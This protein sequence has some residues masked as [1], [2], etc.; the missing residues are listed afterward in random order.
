MARYVVT[1]DIVSLPASGVTAGSYTN[2]DI[3]V[4]SQGIVTAASNG[5]SPAIVLDDLTDVSVGGAIVNQILQFDGA[6]WV[7]GD[8]S[9]ANLSD[10]SIPS[11]SVDEILQYDGADWVS[12]T[13]A[14]TGALT[15]SD[16]GVTV[17]GWDA[18][19]DAL[20]ALATDGYIV[21]TGAGTY[22]TRSIT[23]GT[24]SGLVITHEDGISGDTTIVVDFT[25]FA[26]VT[27]IEEDVDLIAFYND[28]VGEMEVD[29]IQNIVLSAT[30]VIGGDN[31]GSG[32]DVFKQLNTSTKLMEFRELISGNSGIVITEDTNNIEIAVSTTLNQIS[33][34]TPSLNYFIVGDGSQWTAE[35]PSAARSSLGLGTSA[36]NDDTD[37]IRVDGANA[38]AADLDMGSSV[39][40]KIINLDDPVSPQDAA[41]K[42]YVDGQIA[43]A[44]DPG[45]GLTKSVY[46]LNVG[47]GTGIL[48]NPDDVELD[49]SYTDSLYYRKTELNETTPSAPGAA[50]VGTETK[51]NLGSADTVEE[52]LNYIDVELPHALTRLR[53]ELTGT[54]QLDVG[55]P[56]VIVNTKNDVEIAQFLDGHNVAIYRDMML[57]PDFDNTR[58]L[59]FYAAFAKD[60]TL[61]GTALM[62]LSYQ[63][64]RPAGINWSTDDTLTF[65]YSDTEVY[66]LHWTIDASSLL[67]LDTFSLR[68]S[69][70]GGD[71][72]D[73]YLNYINFLTAYLIQE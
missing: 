43:I 19:L 15:A 27:S 17:Q 3:T 70:L 48:V 10:V 35:S 59:H 33:L 18:D 11:P 65:S 13:I 54:W 72:G 28:D 32:A 31:V 44:A 2:A 56:N 6:D 62:A 66:V 39:T 67:P 49:V 30:P 38:M 55:A 34:L 64:Q 40:N 29:T 23:P 16:I 21:K 41:T 68:L 57:P 24:N 51:P 37:Y 7:N 9:L 47:A 53:V 22:E 12:V 8:L 26:S 5:T 58:D 52:A 60:V 4:N 73:T 36:T 46:T 25:Q 14:S 50:L 45:D 69:R 1:E 20:A 63:Y 61:A 42:A 71:A